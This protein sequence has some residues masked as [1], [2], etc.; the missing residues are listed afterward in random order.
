M[1]ERTS[2]KEK[3]ETRMQQIKCIH[4]SMIAAPTNDM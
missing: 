2:K 1:E 4:G 3:E